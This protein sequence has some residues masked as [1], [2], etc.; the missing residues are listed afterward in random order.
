[1]GSW[2]SQPPAASLNV[3]AASVTADT[4]TQSTSFAD[5]AQA[6]VTI[7]TK[8]GNLIVRATGSCS[9]PAGNGSFG[10]HLLVDGTIVAG[11]ES[12]TNVTANN[13]QPWV[14]EA[15]VTGLAA[16]AHV[17]KVQWKNW[18]GSGSATQCRAA[19]HLNA[20]YCTV[21]AHEMSS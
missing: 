13:S 2:V 21:Y 6:T 7:T 5:L 18:S 4:S 19:T 16:A 10:V 20:E 3:V 11:A 8:G 9:N 12:V 14:L 1:M 17:V 15:H